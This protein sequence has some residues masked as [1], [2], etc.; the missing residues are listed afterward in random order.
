V[1]IRAVADAVRVSPPSIYLHFADK[2]A[3]IE[4]VCVDVFNELDAAMLAAAEGLSSPTERLRAFGIAYVDF[5]VEH[6]QHYRV[7]TMECR[8]S[9]DA[10]HIDM[11]LADSAFVHFMS[12]VAA[13]M[14]DGVFPEGDPVPI[15]MQ[16]W[17]AA[18]GVAAL[19][20]AKPF[21]PWGDRRE[22]A[23]AVLDAAALGTA[24]LGA[25]GA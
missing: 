8:A 23:A 12:T 1:S 21:L 20:I 2:D 3:L 16:L 22:F 7:A 14:A 24:A 25:S 9:A 13:C 11:V 15:T 10:S 18:H 17:C 19:M 6:P 5:A 4:A